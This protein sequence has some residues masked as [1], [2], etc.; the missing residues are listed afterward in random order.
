MLRT[1]HLHGFLAT[2]YKTNKVKLYGE[3]LFQIMSGLYHRFGPEFK[4]DIRKGTWQLIKG[5]VNS[6]KDI[7]YEQLEHNLDCKTLHIVPVVAGASGAVRAIVGVILVVVGLYFNQPWLVNIGASM[8]LG[9][10]V[11]ILTKPKTQTPTQKEDDKGTA[12]YN[13]A[14][15]VTSQGGPIP[16]IYGRVGRCSSVV[17]STDFSSDDIS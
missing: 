16:V 11:E 8:A 4:E 9:G 12:V 5:R 2:K 13:G 1:I 14:V 7:G 10:V 17:I 3:N 15:N 6:K